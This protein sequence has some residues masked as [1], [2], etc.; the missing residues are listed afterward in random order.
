MDCKSGCTIN[1][2]STVNLARTIRI[3]K[4]VYGLVCSIELLMHAGSWES[5]KMKM[6]LK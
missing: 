3:K 4:G 5:T 6:I 2:Y 1:W